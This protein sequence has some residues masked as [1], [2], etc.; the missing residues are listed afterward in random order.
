MQEGTAPDQQRALGR[1]GAG[2]AEGEEAEAGEG[3][4]QAAEDGRGGRAAGLFAAGHDGLDS[5]MAPRPA[6]APDRRA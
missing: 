2:E 6:V 4:V 1:H 5:A 3:E